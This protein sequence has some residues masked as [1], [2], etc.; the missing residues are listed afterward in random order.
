MKQIFS[1]VQLVILWIAG[2]MISGIC[3]LY[4]VKPYITSYGLPS[5]ISDP[6]YIYF[7]WFQ[8]YIM[9]IVIQNCIID[10]YSH[11][12]KERTLKYLVQE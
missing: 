9:P 11:L 2:L 5:T 7:D 1:K 6:D 3:Y 12:Q 4:S 8:A 10:Y